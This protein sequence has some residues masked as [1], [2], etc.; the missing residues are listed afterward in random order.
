M[1]VMGTVHEVQEGSL[2]RR[3]GFFPSV[4]GKGLLGDLGKQPVLEIFL[5]GKHDPKTGFLDQIAVS[6]MRRSGWGL[7]QHN[8][9]WVEET[10]Y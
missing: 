2:Y 10:Q 4:I 6:F 3:T 1:I 8:R 5:R 9:A 7:R